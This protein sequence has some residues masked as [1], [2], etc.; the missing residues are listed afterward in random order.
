MHGAIAATAQLRSETSHQAAARDVISDTKSAIGCFASEHRTRHRS[1]ANRYGRVS[2]RAVRSGSGGM[3]DGLD[4]PDENL[5]VSSQPDALLP[6][7]RA[8]RFSF[9]TVERRRFGRTARTGAGSDAPTMIVNESPSDGKPHET[10]RAYCE[11]MHANGNLWRAVGIDQ[12]D[13]DSVVLG[14]HTTALTSTCSDV[15]IAFWDR[16]ATSRVGPQSS[17]MTTGL[18]KHSRPEVSKRSIPFFIG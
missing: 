13:H 2:L 10:F 1:A 8:N 4:D 11:A 16:W 5:G 7:Q 18:W 14:D 6:L 15:L 12:R 3:I 9:K 17:R